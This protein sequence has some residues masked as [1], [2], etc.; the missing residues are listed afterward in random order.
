MAFIFVL[1]FLSSTFSAFASEH[2]SDHEAYCLKNDEQA[3]LNLLKQQSNAV[4]LYSRAWFKL[5][6]YKLDYYYDKREFKKLEITAKPLFDIENKPDVFEMQLNYYY[7]KSLAYFGRKEE[8]KHYA[9]LAIAKLEKIYQIFEDPMRMVEIAN[10]EYVFGDKQKA[11]QLLL[12]AEN[13]FGKRGDPIF[14][15]E[16][17]TNKGH[18]FFTWQNYERAAKFYKLALDWIKDTEHDAKK[19]VAYSNLARTYQLMNKHELAL[20]HYRHTEELLLK[21]KNPRLLAVILIRTAEVYE[22][23]NEPEKVAQFIE[24]INYADLSSGYHETFKRLSSFITSKL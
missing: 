4:P 3:C 13:K 11:Y 9:Q 18:I 21:Q 6:S 17:H 12:L 16:L 1:L 15:L 5:M 8:A 7:A 14:H 10:L 23:L 20:E 22:Q 2:F 24:R 19:V